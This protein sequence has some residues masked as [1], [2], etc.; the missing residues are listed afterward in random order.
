MA[1]TAQERVR[2]ATEEFNAIIRSDPVLSRIAAETFGSRSARFLAYSLKG[3]GFK[4]LFERRG[5]RM[6]CYTTERVR[7]IGGT[8][9]KLQKNAK[10]ASYQ[11][12]TV[13]KGGPAVPKLVRY[14][15]LRKSAQARARAM[16][17]SYEAAT[18]P[19]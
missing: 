14:H 13:K 6:F 5:N 9:A 1:M 15:S 10:F 3:I 7:V 8:A 11:L 2:K 19:S 18:Q 17:D 4:R 16:R 12:V